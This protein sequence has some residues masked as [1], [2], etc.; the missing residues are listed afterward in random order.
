MKASRLEESKSKALAERRDLSGYSRTTAF[1]AI[2]AKP[3][4][5]FVERVGAMPKQGVSSTFKFGQA[6]GV[7]IGILAAL[8]VPV[9]FITP[10]TWKR[11]YGLDADKEKSRLKALQL[12]AESAAF[13]AKKKDHNK[14]EVSLLAKFAA[15]LLREGKA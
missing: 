4:A 10:G 7:L 3:V 8:H 5:A 6:N 15:E 13:F 12:F 9:H 1:I 11:H 2:V 14:A